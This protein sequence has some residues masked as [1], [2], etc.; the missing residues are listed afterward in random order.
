MRRVG[1]LMER[2]KEQNHSKF[3][4]CL[5]DNE[6]VDCVIHCLYQDV[7]LCWSTGLDRLKEYM[8][9]QHSAP[10]LAISIHDILLHWRNR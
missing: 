7:V 2:W 10:G 5:T 1:K 9:R 6:T 4:K 8:L 3:P